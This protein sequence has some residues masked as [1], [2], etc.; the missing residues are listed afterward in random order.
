M[1]R[2]DF[3]RAGVVGTAA[4][5]LSGLTLP[6]QRAS[7]AAIS[8]SLVAESASKTLG[9][10][11]AATTVTVWRFRDAA[12]PSA[13][14]PGAVAAG[15]RVNAG[16]TVTVNL[17]NNLNRPVGFV[18]P[19]LTVTPATA[20]APGS[21]QT[22][23]FSPQQPGSYLFTDHQSDLLGRAMGLA[24]PLV[25]MPAD[26]ALRLAA[27]LETFNSQYTL[28]LNEMDTRLNNA[29]A[30]GGNGT[31]QLGNFEPDYYFVNGLSYPATAS[32]PDT[33]VKLV[34]GQTTALRFVNG[35]L[36]LNSM[37]FHG[38]H[39][40]VILRDRAPEN[41]VVD[42]DTV[43]V[44]LAECVDV[45][46]PVTQAGAYELHNHYLPGVTGNGVYPNGAMIMME[47]T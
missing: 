35:G 38:Y 29:V 42:K 20:T 3:L 22:Y 41:F 6:T 26:G 1:K 8:V 37:H 16:D 31:A 46:L 44:D 11:T 39:V 33:A 45:L 24:G 32:D 43:V 4:F 25:V 27:G 5:T 12:A 19:G 47:A 14:G 13:K 40:K 34:T 28:F 21:T 17:T 18:V 36:Q 15:L 23:T 30:A 10:G 2:R 7:A 9:S